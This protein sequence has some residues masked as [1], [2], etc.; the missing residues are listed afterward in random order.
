MPMNY[1]HNNFYS[2]GFQMLL[3][4]LMLLIAGC[5][6][7]RIKY[8]FS[9]RNKAQHLKTTIYFDNGQIET[10]KKV[11]RV[12]PAGTID[13]AHYTRKRIKHFNKNG[14]IESDTL[15]EEIS[16]VWGNS[17]IKGKYKIR[18]PDGTVGSDTYESKQNGW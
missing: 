4:G 8:G 11:K 1:K 12:Y 6:R 7:M 16:S 5:S 15:Q 14:K 3:L 18:Y 17:H 10:I 2:M 13:A 9:F